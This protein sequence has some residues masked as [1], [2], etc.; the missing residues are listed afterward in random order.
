MVCCGVAGKNNVLKSTIHRHSCFDYRWIS[1]A[2]VL[3]KEFSLFMEILESF[4]SDRVI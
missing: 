3:F 4:V 2:P 1:S